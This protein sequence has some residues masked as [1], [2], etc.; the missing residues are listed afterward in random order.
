[1]KLRPE[2]GSQRHRMTRR[3][4][5]IGTATISLAA[6]GASNASA[7]MLGRR[8]RP[9]IVFILADDLGYADVSCYGRRDYATPAIDSIAARGM[10][11]TQGYANSAVCSATR[12]ALM[13]GRYQ[14][15]LAIGLEEPLIHTRDVGLPP[16]HPTLPSMLGRA[17]YRTYLV[18]KW[19]LGELPDYGPRLSGYD[20]F[21][22]LRGGAI[23]YFSHSLMGKRDFWDD[24]EE[25]VEP[26]YA[27]ELLGRKAIEIIESHRD[28]DTPFFLSLHFTAPH[29]PWEGPEDQAESQ[30]LQADPSLDYQHLDGGSAEVYASM[31]T[32]MDEQIGQILSAI[33]AAGMSDDT[34]VV[35]T[36]DN[37]GERFSDTWPFS[38]KK[39]ELLEGGLRI[40]AIVQYPRHI[41][42]GSKSDQTM[43][44]MDWVPT[45]LSLAGTWPDPAYPP[46]GIDL[47]AVLAGAAPTSRTLCWRYLNLTQEACRSGDW[48]Y[49][50]ILDNTFLF[51][52][53]DDPLERANMKE[54]RPDIYQDLVKKYKDWERRMLPLDLEAFTSGF[55][56]KD[57][58]DHFGV[59]QRRMTPGLE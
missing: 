34:I 28:D 47:S 5:L 4:A 13:T 39:T 3:Q 32:A 14:D 26:G 23:D 17:G 59:T 46:D 52:V 27:T 36:S 37:G 53:A 43:M 33:E 45:L 18:G 44:T 41:P 16:S 15:R 20:H 35:F 42:A 25:I 7:T 1:M 48:K 8:R 40:P 9:N 10:L 57:L 12:T 31:V 51:N 22:G 19:H 2:A 55:T 49:L 29:W 50:K 58:A 30:R 11:F 38:G 56:G 6:A 24:E 54:R 21:W